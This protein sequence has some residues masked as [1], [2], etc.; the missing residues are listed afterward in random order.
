MALVF[1]SSI[2]GA[3]P[4]DGRACR[5]QN[6]QFATDPSWRGYDL[7][8]DAA[9]SQS[10]VVAEGYSAKA[11]DGL[12][13]TLV[14]RWDG[15]QWTIVPSPNFGSL[16]NQITATA[17][18]PTTGDIYSAV[19]YLASINGGGVQ[20]AAL[21]IFDGSSYV[22]IHLPHIGTLHNYP[23]AIVWDP[24]EAAASV[25]V[26]YVD[27]VRS[28]RAVLTYWTSRK[29]WTRI[30]IPSDPGENDLIAMALVRGTPDILV[31]GRRDNRKGSIKGDIF[32]IDPQT[33]Q[34]VRDAVPNRGMN[35]NIVE[36][37]ATT[38]DVA[39]AAGFVQEGRGFKRP[40]LL[41]DAA[42][43]QGGSTWTN[44]GLL[45]HVYDHPSNAVAA[46]MQTDSNAL[47]G[48][49]KSIGG[50]LQPIAWQLDGGAWKINSPLPPS[51]ANTQIS[52]LA[53]IPGTTG[54][55]ASMSTQASGLASATSAFC[56]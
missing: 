38:G 55:V 27:G 51:T 10:F 24:V 9:I 14:E 40:W 41:T 53:S 18:D 16:D 23:T 46:T 30:D 48:G 15:T 12:H 6:V 47:I 49:W 37:L 29:A 17:I 26:D 5:W 8:T 52:A 56:R 4:A 22:T 34:I 20:R 44:G 35:G 39:I 7:T 13:R 50:T 45:P 2:C 11:G 19:A 25:G 42:P 31:G 54:Y 32:W 43:G 33:G 1:V 21:M 3:M 28:R 36:A